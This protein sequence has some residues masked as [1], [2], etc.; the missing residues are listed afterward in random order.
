MK[1]SVYQAVNFGYADPMKF[2]MNGSDYEAVAVVEAATLDEAY[3]L[4]NNID[5]L[6]INNEAVVWLSAAVKAAGG[7]RSTS[8]GD[9]I[10]GRGT[11]AVASFGF[12]QIGA[13]L[14][15]A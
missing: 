5:G 1:M 4:T 11:F 10:V 7:C 9:V 12:D 14:V 6:W 2:N 13:K 8:V 3:E 15:N